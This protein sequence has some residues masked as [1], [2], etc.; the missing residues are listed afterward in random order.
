MKLKVLTIE[1]NEM[2]NNN[3]SLI[4]NK[5]NYTPY[6]ALG[7]KQGLELFNKVQPHIVLLDLKL[8]DGQG[9]NLIEEMRSYYQPRI[10]VLSALNDFESKNSA[11]LK[12]ADDYL[13]K[14]FDMNELILK[15]NAIRE[16]LLSEQV[17]YNIGGIIFDVKVDEIRCGSEHIV[18]PRSQSKV[19]ESLC[20][21][22][23]CKNNKNH[24]IE[25]LEKRNL[26]TIINRLRKNLITLKSN[27]VEIIT[28]Y[29]RGY[30]LMEYK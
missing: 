5:E 27:D 23:L 18:L 4:L 24:Y 14:P 15:L 28:V 3:I 8:P 12:G 13:T 21:M 19:F 25:S 29:G 20:S 6:S 30:A 22:Y 9:D 10:I 7:Y 17:I 11:Y 16:R 2:L 26:E 1:D